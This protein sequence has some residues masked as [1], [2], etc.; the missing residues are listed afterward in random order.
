MSQ[1]GN[2]LRQTP[3][4]VI[5]LNKLSGTCNIAMPA[6]AVGSFLDLDLVADLFI[7]QIWLLCR[8]FNNDMTP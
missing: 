2:F 5:K 3:Y 6:T 8:Q 4:D 7:H 1:V